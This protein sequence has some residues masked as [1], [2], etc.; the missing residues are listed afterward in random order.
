MRMRKLGH[1]QSVI[2]CVPQEIK[3]N[4]KELRSKGGAVSDEIQVSEIL[5]WSIRETWASLQRGIQLWA[6]QGR[7]HEKHHSLWAKFT[8]G[9]RALAADAGKEVLEDE[10]QTILQ[11]YRP[12]TQQ[13]DIKP[14][15][16]TGGSDSILR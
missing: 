8:G 9:Q 14:T 4:I 5:V 6:T 2:F 15:L 3:T 10:A 7:R 12:N 16:N 11:R 1:G 13:Q